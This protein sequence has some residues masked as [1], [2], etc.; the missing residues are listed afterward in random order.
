MAN[1]VDVLKKYLRP[2][3]TYILV[4]IL[5]LIFLYAAQHVYAQYLNKNE[6]FDVANDV[7]DERTPGVFF[8]RRLVSSLQKSSTRV[9]II[10]AGK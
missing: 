10:H 8:P 2:Y 5:I 1:I 3:H 9:E 7:M 6:N 4:V